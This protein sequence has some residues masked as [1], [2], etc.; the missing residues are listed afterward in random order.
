MVQNKHFAKAA[1]TSARLVFFFASRRRHTRYKVTRVQTCALPI[2]R[3]DKPVIPVGNVSPN[4]DTSTVLT[5]DKWGNAVAATP[6]GFDG[7]VVGK[8]GVVLGT[9]LRSFNEIGRASCR[10]RV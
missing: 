10:E 3:L 4:Q 6:S 8:T 1:T 9:R 2:S 5:M 7:L